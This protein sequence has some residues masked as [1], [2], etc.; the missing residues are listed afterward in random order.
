MVGEGV[1][2]GGGG[3]ATFCTTLP[4]RA[5]LLGVRMSWRQIFFAGGH[6]SQKFVPAISAAP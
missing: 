4:R 3:G 1:D 6:L 5:K 2:G